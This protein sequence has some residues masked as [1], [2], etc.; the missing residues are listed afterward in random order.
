MQEIFEKIIDQLEIL[1]KDKHAISPIMRYAFEKAIK[2][3]NQV[4]AE[5][6]E[7]DA[8]NRVYEKVVSIERE[9]AENGD[10]ENVDRCIKLENLMQY[11][12]EELE[13]CNNGYNNGWIPCNGVLYP[14]DMEDVLISMG[15]LKAIPAYRQNGK[16]YLTDCRGSS[17]EVKDQSRVIAWQPLPEPY[18]QKE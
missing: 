5:Y 1:Q 15:G 14:D 13:G 3:V 4:A 8:F 7:N 11:F 2:I 9:Y 17:T 16:W 18:Q 12:K 6:E 10:I